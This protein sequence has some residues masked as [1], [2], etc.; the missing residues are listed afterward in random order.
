[1]QNASLLVLVVE[2]DYFVKGVVQDALTKGGFVSE[3][4]ASGEE[5]I[6]LIKGRHASYRALVIDIGLRDGLRGWDVAKEARERNP[7]IAVVYVTGVDAS[8]WPSRS[9]P[10]SLLLQKPF[11]PAQW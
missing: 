10:N 9:V 3:A 1:M 4:V 7:E 5:A 2:D 6:A 8:H 11:A